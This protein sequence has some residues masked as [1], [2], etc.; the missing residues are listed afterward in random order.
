MQLALLTP[1]ASTHLIHFLLH[2]AAVEGRA[3]WSCH[4]PGSTLWSLC[5]CASVLPERYLSDAHL[6]PGL[7]NTVW[8][9][10]CRCLPPWDIV[11]IRSV[12]RCMKSGQVQLS[13]PLQDKLRVSRRGLLAWRVGVDGRLL[14]FPVPTS[15]PL[16]AALARALTC[17]PCRPPLT[18]LSLSPQELL[19]FLQNLPTARWGDEDISLLLAEAYR[20]KFVFADAPNHYK[21]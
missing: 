19:L 15:Q 3:G 10:A 13:S 18:C 4:A 9:W 16:V 1:G 12:A 14:Q 7:W 21:K 2:R 17:S 20:L 5:M 6:P 8:P 11:G